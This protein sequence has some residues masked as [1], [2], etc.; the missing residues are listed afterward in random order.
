MALLFLI[1]LVFSGALCAVSFLA[2]PF[3]SIGGA[4]LLCAILLMIITLYLMGINGW[5]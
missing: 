1:F 2:A 3:T 4:C 5:I